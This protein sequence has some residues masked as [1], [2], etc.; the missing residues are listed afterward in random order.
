MIKHGWVQKPTTLQLIPLGKKTKGKFWS[1]AAVMLMHM[2][3]HYGTVHRKN[4]LLWVK[5]STMSHCAKRFFVLSLKTQ[6]GERFFFQS[7]SNNLHW[8]T[9][10]G[11]GANTFCHFLTLQ[12]KCV[13]AHRGKLKQ[14]RNNPG[15]ACH[16]RCTFLPVSWWQK[17]TED[18]VQTKL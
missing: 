10:K 18:K 11:E 16:S 9:E 14:V 12:N 6:K 13:Y 2:R 5:G 4:S 1:I 3:K 8:K 7:Y 17:S 15:H